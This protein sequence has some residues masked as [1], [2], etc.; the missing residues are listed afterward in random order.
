[1]PE[2]IRS[3]CV[4]TCKVIGIGPNGRR[5]IDPSKERTDILFFYQNGEQRELCP[6]GADPIHIDAPVGS[7]FIG[8]RVGSI[9]GV[10]PARE[11]I[12]IQTVEEFE[13][14]KG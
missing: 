4:A 9:C 2:R 10:M 13:K 5:A 8:A 3:G 6:G 7:D 14:E 1:M 11:V 12:K